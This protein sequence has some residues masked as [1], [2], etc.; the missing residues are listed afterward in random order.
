MTRFRAAIAVAL[1]VATAAWTAAQVRDPR[2]VSPA[3]AAAGAGISGRGEIESN[4]QRAPVRRAKVTLKNEATGQTWTTAS[5]ADGRYQ[6]EGVTAGAYRVA[7]AKPG[8][9]AAATSRPVEVPPAGSITVTIDLQR[10]GALEGRFNDNRGDPIARLTVTADRMSGT[11]DDAATAAR[12]A[13]IAWH[14]G[15]RLRRRQHEAGVDG[16]RVGESGGAE[17]R[18]RLRIYRARIGV[19]AGPSPSAVAVSVSAPAVRRPLT[20][21]KARP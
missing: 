1:I 18:R 6:F 20:I 2:G 15:L 5:D 17:A 3:P 10:A 16:R 12:G 21:T 8:F 9:V 7:A 11:Q 14:A 19:V 4:R 13:A